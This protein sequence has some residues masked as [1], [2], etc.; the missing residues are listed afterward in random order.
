MNRS[1]FSRRDA[2]RGLG[3]AAAAGISG[4][5]GCNALGGGG[6]ADELTVAY[7]PI[8][9]D[10]QHFVM[11]EEGYFDEIDAAVDAK[12]FTDGPSIVQAYASGEIDIGLFGVVPAMIVIDKGIAA[13]VVA[14]NI[15]EPMMLMAR[16]DFMP[17][18]EEHGA[19]AFAE[20]ERREGRK[21]TFGTFPEGSVP[22][23]LLRYWLIDEQG[24]E[25]G[26]DV[27]IIGMGG[28]NAVRQGLATDEI[29][30]TSI[31]EPVPTLTEEN[32]DPYQPL[33]IAPDF[34]PGQPAAVALM[35]DEVRDSEVGEQF[36]EQ[37]V[38]A[39]EFVN[40]D[41]D[42]TAQHA[43]TVIG[44]ETLSVETARRA[45]DSPISNFVSDP[46]EI[47]NG[48]EIFTEY[49]AELGKTDERLS[50]DDVFDYSLY[51]AVTE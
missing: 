27:E 1:T 37:H 9:P 10:M 20:F 23:I 12:E 47:E 46:R 42:A 14:A 41:P 13:K 15:K 33:A 6:G 49:A 32:G 22:D 35:N 11:Q 28:A 16:D 18:W 2:L 38:R 43:S 24:L 36:V 29:D 50:L 30:G 3:G 17:L 51:D 7:M 25:P 21:F 4:L 31:M 45:L 19:D 8:Y 39:T 34:M 48:T 40:D 44:E 26:E 5:A